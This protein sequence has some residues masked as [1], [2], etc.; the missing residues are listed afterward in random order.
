MERISVSDLPFPFLSR[1]SWSTTLNLNFSFNL[2][3][4]RSSS[5]TVAERMCAA[6]IP[7][8]AIIEIFIFAAADCFSCQPRTKR[9]RYQFGDFSR[10]AAETRCNFSLFSRFPFLL[11]SGHDWRG[12]ALTFVTGLCPWKDVFSRSCVHLLIRLQKRKFVRLW[13]VMT[14]IFLVVVIFICFPSLEV[15]NS[16]H[17]LFYLSFT[18]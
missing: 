11:F 10:I 13:T 15:D 3:L 8:I 5:L 4:Q 1:K 17:F 16:Y 18:K 12:K 9:C 7:L 6:F 2:L 14:C